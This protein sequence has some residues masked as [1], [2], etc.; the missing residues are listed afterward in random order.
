MTFQRQ[1][2]LAFVILIGVLLA[3]VAW[4]TARHG[5]WG[6]KA[7]EQQRLHDLALRDLQETQD[8]IAKMKAHGIGMHPR[9]GSAQH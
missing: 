1:R 3:S 9:S 8:E 6:Q 4:L 7:S 2:I 5:M